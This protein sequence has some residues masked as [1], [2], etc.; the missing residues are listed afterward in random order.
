MLPASYTFTAG[1]E[2]T[3]TF[4]VTFKTAGTQSITATDTVNAAI[5]GTEENILIQAAVAKSLQVT[6]FPTTDTAGASETF[7]V[8]AFDAYGNVATGYIGT[9]HFR[10][11]D[12]K[13][14]LPGDATIF[15][16]DQGTLTFTATLETVGTQSITATDTITSSITGTESGINV[17]AAA[18]SS[19]VVTGFP[20][21]VAAGTTG[22]FTVSVFDP[23]GNLATNY[24]GMVTFSSTDPQ[25]ILPG[26]YTFTASDDGKHIFT[27]TLKTAGTQSITVA[28]SQT[29][30]VTGTESNIIVSGRCGQ[31]AGRHRV[32][33]QRDGGHTEC[34][35][36]DRVS[37]R[38]A[39]W[40]PVTPARW[41]SPVRTRTPCCPQATTSRRPTRGTMSLP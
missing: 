26:S 28:D 39:T 1:D 2:G 13:A 41:L 17:Q 31:H 15:P 16:E 14:I 36:G 4:T 21:S 38:T 9:V 11:S 20:A 37:I 6:G 22:S 5:I 40:R 7:T 32:S 34:A 12:P 24:V 8:T 23:Y 33:D 19:L 18:A 27:A 3:H 29:S 35:D 10:S 30:S 25:V